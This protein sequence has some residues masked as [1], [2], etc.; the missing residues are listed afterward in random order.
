MPPTTNSLA[1]GCRALAEND[2]RRLER[3]EPAGGRWIGG[4][5]QGPN[6]I[7]TALLVLSPLMQFRFAK[8]R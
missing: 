8:S 6:V 1:A 3:I 4:F 2:A 7:V 5:A